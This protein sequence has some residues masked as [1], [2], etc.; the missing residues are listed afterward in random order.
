MRRLA[1]L[2][3]TLWAATPA[4]AAADQRAAVVAHGR[5]W[6]RL[7]E[8]GDIAGLRPLY[9]PDAILMTNG[10][11]ILK[12]VD[13]ILAYLGRLK[14]SGGRATIDF[15]PEDVTVEGDRATLI[16]KYWL[17][18]MPTAGAPIDARGRSFLV[19]KKGRD[20]AWRLWRD[21][22]NVAPD[23]TAAER[24]GAIAG[25]RRKE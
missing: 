6:K 16:A 14:A 15:A 10:A 17:T 11:P 19:L 18:I 2:V 7:Y 20:G 22:D 13:A 24:P 8:A 9:E 12:G 4:V 3:L 25:Q 21:I 23:V 5:E 1:L